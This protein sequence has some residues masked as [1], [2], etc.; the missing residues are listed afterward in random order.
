M[1]FVV[2]ILFGVASSTVAREIQDGAGKWVYSKEVDPLTDEIF[3]GAMLKCDQTTFADPRYFMIR[4]TDSKWE[5]AVIWNQELLSPTSTLLYRFGDGEVEEAV[6]FSG[7]ETYWFWFD[8]QDIERFVL[9][10]LDVDRLVVALSPKGQIRQSTTFSVRG[11]GETLLPHLD[12]LGW[13]HLRT[14]I[15]KN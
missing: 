13:G 11:L 12:D 3:F 5:M 7:D 6:G 1:L 8:D 9:R 4:Y 14:E 10:L 15:R 2:S